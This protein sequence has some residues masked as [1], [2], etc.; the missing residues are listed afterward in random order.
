MSNIISPE[1]PPVVIHSRESLS[2]PVFQQSDTLM[3]PTRGSSQ[4]SL[5]SK[6]NY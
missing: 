4:I 3:G 6:C 2:K 5:I 1:I